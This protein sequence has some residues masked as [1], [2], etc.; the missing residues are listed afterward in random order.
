M[1]DELE[2]VTLRCEPKEATMIMGMPQTRNGSSIHGIDRKCTKWAMLT[3][4]TS[5]NLVSTYL[6]T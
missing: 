5:P 3:P 1:L 2:V 4:N 6:G